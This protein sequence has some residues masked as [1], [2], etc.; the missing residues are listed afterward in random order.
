[1]QDVPEN[2][3][4]HRLSESFRKGRA[5]MTLANFFQPYTFSDT[6][7]SFQS[8]SLKIF[9]IAHMVLLTNIWAYGLQAWSKNDQSDV[10]TKQNNYEL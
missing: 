10:F 8:A 6:R 4:V 5:H 3:K 1:V 9:I 2:V 7:E